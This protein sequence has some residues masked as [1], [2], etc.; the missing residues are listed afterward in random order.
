[1]PR[2]HAP[3]QLDLFTGLGSFALGARW[4][5]FEPLAFSE[6]EPFCVEHLT[7]RFPGIP[8][9]GDVRKF[10]RRIGDCDS[11]AEHPEWF[12]PCADPDD[13]D[14]LVVCPICSAEAGHP[15]DF[16]ECDCIGTDQ[17]LD[18]HGLPDVITAGFPCQDVSVAQGKGAKGLAGQRS[19]LWAEVP[20]IAAELCPPFILAENVPA[21]KTRGFDQCAADLE[22]IGYT[23]APLVVPVSPWGA[24]HRRERVFIVAHNPRIGMEGVWTER[25]PKPRCVDPAA[26]SVRH[27]DGQ[28]KS[29]PDLRRT[30]D[31]LPGRLDRSA[32]VNDRLKAIGNSVHPEVACTFLELIRDFAIAHKLGVQTN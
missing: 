6:V 18:E 19:G 27:R 22:A 28:W 13:L 8:N 9:V 17:F 23:V 3:K 25:I 14:G 11:P 1:M 30:P 2:P 26:L 29:E 21:L 7:R 31:G 32:R 16:G 5:G 20:R 12:D 24:S 4:A 15:V 10:C